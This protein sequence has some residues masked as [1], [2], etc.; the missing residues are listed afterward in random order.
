MESIREGGNSYCKNPPFSNAFNTHYDSFH[1]IFLH[2]CL[3]H[4]S[5]FEEVA[6]EQPIR[7]LHSRLPGH[8]TEERG[9]S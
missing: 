3:Y 1:Q 6:D 7:N 9:E 2:Y 5:P 8:L 4:I